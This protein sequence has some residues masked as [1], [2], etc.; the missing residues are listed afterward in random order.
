MATSVQ[1]GEFEWLEDEKGAI[2][3]QSIYHMQMIILWVWYSF[4]TKCYYRCMAQALDG[5]KLLESVCKLCVAA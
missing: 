5:L 3:V 2:Q 4:M 1:M